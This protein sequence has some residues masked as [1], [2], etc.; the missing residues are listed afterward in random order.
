MISSPELSK[1]LVCTVL[2]V[3]GCSRSNEKNEEL[4][5][6]RAELEVARREAAQARA[7][8]K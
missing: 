5:Q 6:A 4:A 8:L 3:G 1:L 2:L 7:E